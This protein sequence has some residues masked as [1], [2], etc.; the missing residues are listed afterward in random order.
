[1]LLVI[2]VLFGLL[3]CRWAAPL[4][5]FVAIVSIIAYVVDPSFTSHDLGDAIGAAV[6]LALLAMFLAN[7]LLAA[8]LTIA[9]VILAWLIVSWVQFAMLHGPFALLIAVPFTIALIVRRAW[10]GFWERH[11]CQKPLSVP[12]I[13]RQIT[14]QMAH[15]RRP[16][17]HDPRERE[18][19]GRMRNYLS[20]RTSRF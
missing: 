7:P 3:A 18:I 16:G 8:A 9:L 13:E 19:E 5:I 15:W 14:H 10:L 11:H 17:F 12:D 4:A 2:L 1:M 6:A 20:A